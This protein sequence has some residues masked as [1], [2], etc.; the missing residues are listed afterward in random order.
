MKINK[1][2]FGY[3]VGIEWLNLI[4]IIIYKNFFPNSPMHIG[5]FIFLLFMIFVLPFGFL[6]C[7]EDEQIH[8]ESYLQESQEKLAKDLDYKERKDRIKIRENEFE[9]ERLKQNIKYYQQSVQTSIK[10]GLSTKIEDR[11]IQESTEKLKQL[12]EEN[13]KLTVKWERK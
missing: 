8:R 5:K 11:Y 7:A 13:A 10:K 12:E 9:I 3:F 1:E 2:T 6:L 4:C